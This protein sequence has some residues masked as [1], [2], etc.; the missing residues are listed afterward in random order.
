LAFWAFI[1]FHFGL[2]GLHCLSFWPFG[3]KLYPFRKRNLHFG[4]FGFHF[5]FVGFISFDSGLL[6][7]NCGAHAPF[8]PDT[9][10][11]KQHAAVFLLWVAA[12]L[13]DSVFQGC[14]L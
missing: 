2:L 5:W 10:A 7:A 8:S 4:L 9:G 1:S 11:K 13:I 12:S 14:D 3:G 6:A